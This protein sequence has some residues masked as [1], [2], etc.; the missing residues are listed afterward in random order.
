MTYTEFKLY[1]QAGYIDEMDIDGLRKIEAGNY[2]EGGMTDEDIELASEAGDDAW[3]QFAGEL[4]DELGELK[5]QRSSAARA[6]RS[7]PSKKRSDT[8]RANGAK[9]GRPM[10]T[11]SALVKI[12]NGAEPESLRFTCEADDGQG[13]SYWVRRQ[14]ATII[15]LNRFQDN[16][17]GAIEWSDDVS[18]WEK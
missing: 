9:G 5:K 8:S 11:T 17:T 13:N 7:I 16:E 12:Q 3:Q 2:H 4:A 15:R 14:G 6:L 1:M 10:S 18:G